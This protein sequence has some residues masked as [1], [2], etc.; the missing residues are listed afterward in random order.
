MVGT[1]GAYCGHIAQLHAANPELLVLAYDLGPYTQRGTQLYDTLM[2]THPE[3]FARDAAGNLLTV[4][5]ASGSPSFPANTLMEPSSPDWRTQEANRI[6]DLISCGF[7]GIYIDSMGNGPMTGTTTGIPVNPATGRN[8]TDTEWL[9]QLAQTMQ[10]VRAKLGNKFIMTSGLVNG[11]AYQA[12][13][14]ILSDSPIDGIMTDSWIRVAN[15]SVTSYPSLNLFQSNLDM[16]QSLQSQGK[17]FFG[18]TKVWL[19]NATSAD[20]TQWDRFGLA[21][22][23]LVRGPHAYYSFSTSVGAD[24]TY[25]DN[26]F[27]LA[28]LGRALGPYSVSGGVYTRQFENGMVTVNPVGQTASIVVNGVSL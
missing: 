16:V 20:D 13:T 22:Y 25:I 3:D 8:Y 6:A 28:A 17:S 26:S 18:W 9:T 11:P 19:S 27:E 1:P 2:A 10:V 14:H 21:S 12:S 5:A 15:Q 24:R 23:L 7:D 4:Q